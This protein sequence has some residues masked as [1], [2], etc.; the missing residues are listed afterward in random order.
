ML[1]RIHNVKPLSVPRTHGR[2]QRHAEQ[3][4]VLIGDGSDADDVLRYF[5]DMWPDVEGADR[6]DVIS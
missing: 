3:L 6:A 4:L 5:R 2:T 1:N